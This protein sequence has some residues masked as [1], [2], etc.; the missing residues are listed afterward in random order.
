MVCK[1]ND[2]IKLI[3]APNPTADAG[4]DTFLC[5]GYGVLIGG[6]PTAIGGTPPYKYEWAPSTGLS[7]VNVSNPLAMHTVTQ[8][9]N[10]LYSVKV[11]DKYG[12]SSNDYMSL[13]IGS[14]LTANAGKD[15]GM[16]IGHGIV[17]GSV[18]TARGGTPPYVYTWTPATGLSNNKIPNPTANPSITTTYILSVLDAN[19]CVAYDTIKN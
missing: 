3:V 8:T 10:I 13:R 17:I 16:C 1:V 12:C 15:T 5:S 14:Y 2:Q 4:R 19:N 18:V 6:A 9:T 7:N 11:S